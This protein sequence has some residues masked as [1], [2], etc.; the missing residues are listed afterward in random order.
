MSRA[1][2]Q[3][4]TQMLC[5]R[6]EQC[7]VCISTD[8]ASKC[9]VR[10]V[11][12]ISECL[13]C[14]DVYCS[15]QDRAG[16]DFIRHVYVGETSRS[17]RERAGEH[18]AGAKRLDEGNFISK[19]WQDKHQHE[20]DPPTFVFRVNRIHKDPLSRE[21]HE[22]TLI[23]EV[24]EDNVILNSKSEWNNISLSRLTIERSDW[25]KKK[26]IDERDS[27]RAREKEVSKNF[28]RTKLLQ[29][30]EK[31]SFKLSKNVA[32]YC[33]DSSVTVMASFIK[34]AMVEQPTPLNISPSLE[35]TKTGFTGEKRNENN[36]VQNC[37]FNN[38]N[39]NYSRSGKRKMSGDNMDQTEAKKNKHARACPTLYQTEARKNKNADPEPTLTKKA[40][41]AYSCNGGGEAVSV[42]RLSQGY[43]WRLRHLIPS[44]LDKGSMFN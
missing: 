20:A 12:Y 28:K 2:P 8:K 34:K 41:R 31:A 36:V 21:I 9:Q 32:K 13:Q 4:M 24:R 11:V 25:A 40:L 19:H 15:D 37:I 27:V 43:M 29:M 5:N 1:I 23:Q 42:K 35:Q 18:V 17:L 38:T 22:A 7:Q 3:P 26:E 16:N 14:W 33:T 6:V 39:F 30:K 10:N 44:E